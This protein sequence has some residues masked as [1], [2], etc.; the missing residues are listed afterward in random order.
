MDALIAGL[1]SFG[2]I[3]L[4]ELPDK[5]LWAS[6]V[7]S[8]RYRARPVLLGVSL[9]FVVQCIVAVVA[10][11]LLHRLPET[12]IEIAVG[13]LFL[14][15]AI[16]LIRES[17]GEPEHADLEAA[18]ARQNLPF[19]R[20]T[21]ISF[22]IIFAAEWGDASQLATAALEARLGEPIAVGLGAFLALVG[23]AA[24]AIY[25]GEAITRRIPVRTVHRV[26]GAM[27]VVFAVIAYVQAIRH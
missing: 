21:W 20:I 13:T 17:L 7:L 19:W 3:L 2:V 11:G 16:L 18:E 14:I 5:T 9:A 12:A 4:V 22:G 26:A 27:F 6:L 10:G 15:G 24:V 25:A 1:T 23:V 8:T